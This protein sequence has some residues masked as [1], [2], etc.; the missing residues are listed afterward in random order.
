M[1]R[2]KP[3]RSTA[4]TITLEINGLAVEAQPG[5]TI[6]DAARQAG[7]RIPTLCH[8]K[9]CSRAAPAACASWRWRAAPA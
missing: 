8:L 2:P 1:T 3:D 7:V 5:A 4:A 9:G 6:L